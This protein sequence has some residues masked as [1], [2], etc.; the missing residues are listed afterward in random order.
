[1]RLKKIVSSTFENTD[2]R[3]A[4]TTQNEIGKLFPYKDRVCK[5]HKRSLV[6]YK[7]TCE[8]CKAGYI[9]KTERILGYR[10]KEHKNLDTSAVHQH[11]NDPKNKDH[12]VDWD[13]IEI[14]DTADSNFKLLIKEKIHIEKLKP[15]LNI[16]LN[17]SKKKTNNG[18][19]PYD[20]HLST[21]I[22]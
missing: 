12:K 14:I 10:M 17:E 22:V 7:I 6:V 3:V 1:M 20:S 5:T 9:G 19:K 15:L 16:Q 2:L 11:L 4:F 21:F 8:S 18:K 13:K